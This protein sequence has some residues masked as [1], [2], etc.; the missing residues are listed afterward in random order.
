MNRLKDKVVIITGAGSGQ[1][2]TEARLFAA[3][4]AKL[5]LTDI[6]AEAGEQ[7]AREIG[8]QAIFVKHDVSREADWQQ[9]VAAA[10]DKFGRVD[11]LINNAGIYAQGRFQEADVESFDRFFEVNARGTFL[12]MK[13]VQEP[14]L[15]AGGGSIVNISSLVGTRG[16]ANAFSYSTSKWMVRG[17]S[18]CAAVDLAES[19]IRVNAILPGLID[20]PM[21]RVNKPEFLEAFTQSIPAK[22]L[23]TTEDIAHAALYLASDESA[24]IMGAEIAVCGAVGA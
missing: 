11:V 8:D 7:V 14:M 1:G 24:Y 22:R 16:M 17:I 15:K 21:I 23:G 20:T 13:A 12:G 5:I 10:L 6:N 19:N 3:E 18:K 4:G 2:A 9:V